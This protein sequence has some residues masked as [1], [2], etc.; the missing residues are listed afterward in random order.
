MKKEDIL[1][2]IVLIAVSCTA[3]YLIVPRYVERE[4]LRDTVNDLQRRVTEQE[5]ETRRLRREISQL[6]TDPQAIERVA[7]EKF[8]WCAEG[9]KIYHFDSRPQPDRDPGP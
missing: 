1:L 5:Q 4:R 8:G 9:E 6:R 7:R 3:L 2:V